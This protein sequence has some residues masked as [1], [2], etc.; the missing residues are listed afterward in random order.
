MA[1]LA[2]GLVELSKVIKYG[3]GH[4]MEHGVWR[5]EWAGRLLSL[6]VVCASLFT[7]CFLLSLVHVRQICP[8]SVATSLVDRL[9]RDY[10]E[11]EHGKRA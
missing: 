9:G 2:G 10:R 4:R 5:R 11:E 1:V 7:G 8:L 3:G 6:L